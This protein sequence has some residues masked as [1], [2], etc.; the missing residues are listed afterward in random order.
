M[1][2][3]NITQRFQAFVENPQESFWGGKFQTSWL[4]RRPFR[5]NQ[6]Y[7]QVYFDTNML[8]KDSFT[9]AGFS[10]PEQRYLVRTT[11]AGAAAASHS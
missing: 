2:V 1:R 9:T 11:A 6:H 4:I 8:I 10:V 7:W 3:K 5:N